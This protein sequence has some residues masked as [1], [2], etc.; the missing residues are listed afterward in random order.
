M[1]RI[2]TAVIALPILIASILVPW[3][4]PL[5]VVLAGAAMVLGLYEF[6][7]LSAKKATRPMLPRVIWRRGTIH[8]LLL[9]LAL[10]QAAAGSTNYCPCRCRFDDGYSGRSHVQRRAFQQDDYLFRGTRFLA[11]CMW[12]YWAVIWWRFAP[13]SNSNS[14]RTC[15][16][17][18]FW[19]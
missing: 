3:L 7:V 17:F 15:C 18:S 5:F 14:P 10:D 11:C 16:R 8:D 2:I 19:C 9:C 4:L 6:Y 12:F 13:A 1:S